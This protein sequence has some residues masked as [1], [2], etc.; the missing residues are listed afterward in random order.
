MD[1]SLPKVKTTTTKKTTLK[2]GSTLIGLQSSLSP[3]EMKTFFSYSLWKLANNTA[4]VSLLGF[5]R[6]VKHI[7]RILAIPLPGEGPYVIRIRDNGQEG[8]R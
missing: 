6:K 5:L 4:H 8:G 1:F 3:G 7:K 2:Y